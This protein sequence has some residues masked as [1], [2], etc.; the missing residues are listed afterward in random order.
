LRLSLGIGKEESMVE[1]H[2][3]VGTLVVLAFLVLT[4][5]NVVRLTG[6]DLAFARP[7]AMAGAA[8]LLLQYVLGFGLLGSGRRITPVHFLVAL[9][10]IIPVG[11]DHGYAANRATPRARAAASLVSAVLALILVLIAYVIGSMQETESST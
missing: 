9:L 11:M 6:R 7:V 3:L 5:I 4:V 1:F 8:L 2:N 10:A